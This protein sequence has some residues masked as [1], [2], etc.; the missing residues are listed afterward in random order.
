MI[1]RNTGIP[2]LEAHMVGD[3]LTMAGCRAG[4][5]RTKNVYVGFSDVPGSSLLAVLLRASANYKES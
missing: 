5:H 3:M 4:C 2:I 1:L